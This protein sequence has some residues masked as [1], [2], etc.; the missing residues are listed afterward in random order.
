MPNACGLCFFNIGWADPPT[1]QTSPSPRA[2]TS[3]KKIYF[4]L[5]RTIGERGDFH[6]QTL[7][8]VFSA[9]AF[10]TRVL[11]KFQKNI[12]EVF[13]PLAIFLKFG[14]YLLRVWEPKPCGDSSP[15]TPIAVGRCR[16]QRQ[17]DLSCFGCDFELNT[18]FVLSGLLWS[19]KRASYFVR[20]GLRTK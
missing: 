7:T 17:A 4:S 12:K 9:S 11:L 10:I 15:L 5:L 8:P 19:S 20:L 1:H 6:T 2:R 13:A 14:T 16:K 3:L 18:G